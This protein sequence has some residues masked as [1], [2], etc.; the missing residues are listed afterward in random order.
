MIKWN[1]TSEELVIINRIINRYLESMHILGNR[2]RMDLLMDI[3]A[4]HCNKCPLKLE[5]LLN[6]EDFDFMHDLIGIQT[7]L[8]RSTGELQNCFVPRYAK[9]EEN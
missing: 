6:A 3:T 2:S 5:E 9:E 4:T 8:D 7:N 1:A